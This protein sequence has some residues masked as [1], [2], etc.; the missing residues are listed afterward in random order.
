MASMWPRIWNKPSFACLSSRIPYG[1]KID[2]TKIDQLDE[3]EDYLYALGFWPVRVRHH[4][5]I[6]RIEVMPDELAKV[7]ELHDQIHRKFTEIGFTYVTL[8]LAGYKTGSMNAVLKKELP[9][10][11]KEAAR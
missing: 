11:V 9:V 6:A 7:I 10:T 2:K 1:T 4:D 5:Q 3:A 8:D